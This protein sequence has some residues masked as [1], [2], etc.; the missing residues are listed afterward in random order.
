MKKLGNFYNM[1]VIFVIILKIIFIFFVVL[2]K[3]YKY[4]L[5]NSNKTQIAYYTNQYNLIYFWKEKIENIFMIC[6]GFICVIIFNPFKNYQF[7]IDKETRLLL[8]LFGIII[9][10][11]TDWDLLY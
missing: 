7:F 5:K 2:T 11:T 10:F 3:Y 1:F 6:M 4:K 9:F 8:F